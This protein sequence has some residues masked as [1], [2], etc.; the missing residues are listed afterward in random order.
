MKGEKSAKTAKEKGKKQENLDVKTGKRRMVR[1]CTSDKERGKSKTKKN[2]KIN[3]K[4]VDNKFRD[5]ASTKR[6]MEVARVKLDQKNENNTRPGDRRVRKT[7]E[8][9][10]KNCRKR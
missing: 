9:G 2:E 1:V 7:R 5:M 4:R 8:G 10:L 3:K 6:L